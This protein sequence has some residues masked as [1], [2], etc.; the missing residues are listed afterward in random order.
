VS[1][2]GLTCT[3]VVWRSDGTRYSATESD[4]T[5]DVVCTWVGIV[6]YKKKDELEKWFATTGGRTYGTQLGEKRDEVRTARIAELIFE[7]FDVNEDVGNRVFVH[8]R[9][10]A[11]YEEVL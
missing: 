5:I 9:D 3:N 2:F 10:V 7:E 6:S 4:N 1:L 11:L 8:H